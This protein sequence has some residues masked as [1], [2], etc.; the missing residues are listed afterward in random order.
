MEGAAGGGRTGRAHPSF[1][2]TRILRGTMALL[3]P[4]LLAAGCVTAQDR[5]APP[6]EVGEKSGF[7]GSLLP[8]P[9][10]R[11]TFEKEPLVFVVGW[12][13]M[14]A[15][16]VAGGAAFVIAFVRSDGGGGDALVPAMV[17]C[18]AGGA[19]VGGILFTLPVRG[20]EALWDLLIG[21]GEEIGEGPGEA[22][23]REP[24]P[25]G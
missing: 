14:V 7:V 4:A 8:K 25:D 1:P 17:I 24:A 11:V 16:G 15:G 12:T 20:L 13:G 5:D 3:L 2:G 10:G 18:V 19:V 21:G 23:P 9:V 6:A 22:P